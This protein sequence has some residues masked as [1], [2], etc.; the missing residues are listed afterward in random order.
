MMVY[1]FRHMQ[2]NITQAT[3]VLRSYKPYTTGMLL[4]II[5][6][7]KQQGSRKQHLQTLD[8]CAT[9]LLWFSNEVIINQLCSFLLGL[10]RQQHS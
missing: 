3:F 7:L 2:V 8:I 5:I 10:F 6:I 9:N 1:E 4:F